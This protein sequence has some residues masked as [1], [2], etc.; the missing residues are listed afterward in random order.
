MKRPAVLEPVIDR[1][2]NLVDAF[3][4]VA[5][6]RFAFAERDDRWWLLLT[7]LLLGHVVVWTLQ[8][9]L[10]HGNLADSVDMVENWVWGK[11]WQLGYWKHPPFFAWVVGAWFSVFPRADWAYYLLAALNAAIGLSGVWAMTGVADE[12][13]PD[14]GRRRRLVALAG[15]AITPITGFLALKF[16]ANAIL[17]SVWPWATWAFLRALKTPT[18]KNGAILGALLAV[19]M[20]SKY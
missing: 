19:A 9:V 6:R 12:G 11:E 7:L 18:A 15:L 17:L 2:K 8:P 14:H 20:L 10:S 4:A 13:R 1:A 3:E 16:N 5:E